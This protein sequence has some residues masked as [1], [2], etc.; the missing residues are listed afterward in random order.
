MM[1]KVGV[2]IIGCGN[3]SSVYLNTCKSFDVLDIRA[4]A[5][6]V[7]ERAEA[8]A[9][10]FG[11]PV[12]C[13]VETL[14]SDPLIDVVLNLTIPNAHAGISRAALD[15]GKSVYGE[16]PMATTFADCTAILDAAARRGLLVGAAPDTFLG[17]GLQMCRAL[18]DSGV[19]GEPIGAAAFMTCHGHE[20]WH[21]DPAFYYQPGGGPMYD[22]G[23]YYLTALVSLLGP[24]ECVTGAARISFPMRTISSTPR[25]GET[26]DV[27]VPTHVT[28]IL[29][30]SSGVV[31]TITTSFDVW[32]SE[33]PWIEIYGSRGT[34]SLPDPNGFG[35][36][37]RVWTKNEPSWLDVPLS[38]NSTANMRGIGLADM[39]VALQA[40][41]PHR[42]NG[43]MAAH[44]VEIMESIHL[45]AI[46]GRHIELTSSCSRP[47]VL[48]EDQ[49]IGSLDS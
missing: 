4:C 14:L 49:P 21:P 46:E 34:L 11:I 5:D 24:V 1:R 7:L 39:A 25:S 9:A 38:T 12:A 23:P 29:S 8:R 15:A 37:V 32:A 16:K 36:P 47:A 35:G 26:I 33:L 40:G 18:I 3:I 45:A 41:R 13:T 44:V 22:M 6:M 43:H 42:A 27:T 30:F 31:G 28:G 10:E 20:H 48:V 2:G 19:I 17:E